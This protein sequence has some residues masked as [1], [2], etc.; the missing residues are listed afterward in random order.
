MTLTFQIG[1]RTVSV[2]RSEA[3][4]GTH[5]A[6]DLAIDDPVAA[7]RHARLVARGAD[8]AVVPLETSTGTYVNGRAIEG[9]TALAEG[10]VLVLGATRIR[11]APYDAEARAHVVDVDE[12]GFHHVAK[13]RGEFRSDADERVRTEVGF[14]RLPALRAGVAAVLVS[15]VVGAVAVA[16]GPTERALAWG[17][18]GPLAGDAHDLAACADCHTGATQGDFAGVSCRECHAELH[19]A[20]PIAPMESGGV[21][22]FREDGAAG[23]TDCHRIHAHAASAHAGGIDPSDCD[24]CHDA[25]ARER[26]A[27]SATGDVLRAGAPRDGLVGRFRH[28]DHVAVD[29][30][31]AACHGE[32]ASASGLK[33]PSGPEFCF[34]CHG[35]GGTSK[36]LIV[37]LDLAEHATARTELCGRCHVGEGTGDGYAL[38]AEAV[39]RSAVTFAL[40]RAHHHEQED[41]RACH[42]RALPERSR[43]SAVFDH[44]L[45][46]DLGAGGGDCAACHAAVVGAQSLG[47]ATDPARVDLAADCGACHRDPGAAGGE[48][49][50]ER[51]RGVARTEQ[52]STH[53][54]HASHAASGHDCADCHSFGGTGDD[55]G[56]PGAWTT[57]TCADCH[58]ERRNGE[59]RHVD[60]VG[61]DLCVE[62]HGDQLMGRLGATSA[63]TAPARRSSTFPHDVHAGAGLSCAQCHSAEADREAAEGK[64][65]RS[66]HQGRGMYHWW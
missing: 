13:R 32:P 26:S 10:D 20:G 60:V 30:A 18:P 1:K 22:P 51:Q 40:G 35:R 3:L 49:R 66:C 56:R 42:L 48:L 39:E 14:G 63:G 21:H 53:F 58:F 45:H 19:G 64:T 62:C 43:A 37:D 2:P 38:R 33:V 61:G 34:E 17:S 46:V 23:C 55:L 8:L 16:L 5:A 50:I 52:L 47:S 28:G 6:C 11:I 12:R 36:E 25:G 41:C 65:C 9:E 31:C 27:A 29:G 7:S 15:V 59:G 44:A 57:K 24:A 54:S 4:V